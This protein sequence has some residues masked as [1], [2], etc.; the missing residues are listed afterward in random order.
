MVSEWASYVKV[1]K[2]GTAQ[3]KADE[4][5]REAN[6][7]LNKAVDNNTDLEQRLLPTAADLVEEAADFQGKAKEIEK[8]EKKR[9]CGQ[10]GI[11]VAIFV[12]IL[13]VVAIAL[14]IVF[15]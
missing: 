4:S 13:I 2:I 7:A 3:Q 1:D 10:I 8:E 6:L 15:K 5:K 12:G 11:L 9:R 14:A